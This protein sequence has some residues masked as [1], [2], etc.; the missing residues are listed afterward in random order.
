MWQ[1]LGEALGAKESAA[2]SDAAA[3]GCPV[4]AAL[5]QELIPVYVQ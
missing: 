3:F 2:I 5:V 4:Y 1:G